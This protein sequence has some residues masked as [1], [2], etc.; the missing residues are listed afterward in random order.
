MARIQKGTSFSSSFSKSSWCFDL[1][2]PNL[3][4]LFH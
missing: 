4:W 3:F 2:L 1:Q